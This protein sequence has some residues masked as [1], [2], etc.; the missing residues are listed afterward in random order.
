MA[1]VVNTNV[2]SL[3]A[4][5]QLTQT[6]NEM[7]TAMERLSSGQRINSASDDAAGLAI[8]TR[9]T[10]QVKGLT[11]AIRN[12]NDGISLVQTAEGAME[13]VTSMLQ[14]MRELTVQASNSVNNSVDIDA[15]NDEIGQL[16]AEID[17]VSSTTRFNNQT[18]LDGSYAA[19]LQ[20]GDQADQSLSFGISSIATSAMGETP[21][22]LSSA[23]Q[24][25][26]LSLDGVSQTTSDYAGKSFT[27]T[28]NGVDSVVTLPSFSESAAAPA[29]ASAVFA[30]EDTGPATSLLIGDQKFTATQVDFASIANRVFEVRNGNTMDSYTYIDF[31]DALA[32]QLGMTTAELNAGTRVGDKD[33]NTVVASDLLAALQTALDSELADDSRVVVSLDDKGALEFKDASGNIDRVSIR[34]AEYTA[35]GTTATGTFVAGKVDDSVAAGT[36][37]TNIIGAGGGTFDF[38]T[39]DEYSV[40]KVT[41]NGGTETT[42]DF[43]DKLNDTSIVK[44]RSA[45]FAFELVNAMQAELDELF[46]GDDA[47]TVDMTSDGRFTFSVA[48]SERSIIIDDTTF[49]N[50]TG[51]AANSSFAEDVLVGTSAAF[52]I[53]NNSNAKS[54]TTLSSITKAF[55]NDNYAINVQ[56]NG[57]SDVNI[58]LAP[59]LQAE[60]NDDTAITGE[61]VVAALQ[62]AFDDNF[63]GDDAITVTLTADAKI[64]FDVAGGVETL[65]LAEA[66]VNN[67]ATS[68]TFVAT[69]IDSGGSLSINENVLST[70][71]TVN[72]QFGN[73]TYGTF[74]ATS[75]AAPS[76]FVETL[77]GEDV[78]YDIATG[79]STAPGTGGT[80]QAI[81]AAAP[82]DG[83]DKGFVVNATNATVTIALDNDSKS[84]LT[85]DSGVYSNMQDLADA[86]QHEINASFEFRGDD[87]ITVSV[88]SY[89]NEASLTSGPLDYL[90]ISNA[91]GKEIAVTGAFV[92]DTTVNDVAAFGAERDSL[93][94][95]TNLY[96]ELGIDPDETNYRS[97]GRTDGGV[98]T[99]VDSGVVTLAVTN[100]GNVYSYEIALEQDANTSFSDFSSDLLAK[101]NAAFSA[102]GISFT[103]GESDGSFSMTAVADGTTTFSLSGNI[104]N[105]AFGSTLTGASQ[106]GVAFESMDDIAERIAEDISGV[107]V[108][109][110]AE[111]GAIEITDTSGA[112]GAASAIS[113]SGDE[114]ADIEAVSGSSAVGSDSDATGVTLNTINVSTEA[115]ATSALTSIDNALEYVSAQR[116]ELG[117]IENRLTHTVNNLSNVV[118]NTA[119]SRSRIA[120]ADFASEAAN[121]AKLQVMQQAGT[122]M[123]AQANA[124]AQV[125]LSLLG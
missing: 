86:I 53:D 90:Q 65:E 7:S 1:L 73:M 20:I 103:G 70:S 77:G 94:D 111:T 29:S 97:H 24:A 115:G 16:T 93:I 38:A 116:S 28:V 17:R 123:L 122:A 41:V 71:G 12:A 10:S 92:T 89:T 9:M 2:G 32:S 5:R 87:A 114:L 48:G 68:G 21:S 25:A 62:A 84:Q 119:A 63:S 46:T 58:D 57:G 55:E 33:S 101:A 117:A 18:I 75:G 49:T 23:A 69:F 13:E 40:F 125:V 60:I 67:D 61:E 54:N 102:Q 118:E 64:N 104:V 72:S 113:V 83:S 95:D 52:T 105:D 88:G 45:M 3:N 4:Q 96:F 124:Q 112:V 74:S 56:V 120:D 106:S 80:R 66:N 37:A 36:E 98:D 109:F 82:D 79:Y 15:I 35:S 107:D 14:R 110:N 27:V 108:S 76:N 51:A 39:T 19:N 34:D 22:G 91:Y 100:E 26:V 11:M 59:Y 8:S 47:V 78:G 30:G 85:I 50:A 121:L 43:L 6:T 81:F 99:S 31:S 42:V 44:D